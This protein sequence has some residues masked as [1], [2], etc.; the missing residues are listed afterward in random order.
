MDF[1]VN[2]LLSKLENC[3]MVGDLNFSY[4]I[5]SNNCD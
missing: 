5:G 1:W 4:Y 3:W 2:Q